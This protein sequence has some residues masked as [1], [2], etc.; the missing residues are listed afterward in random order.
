MLCSSSRNEAWKQDGGSDSR[1]RW[2]D[3]DGGEL[4]RDDHNFEEDDTS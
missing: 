4:T 2:R 3:D 1:K